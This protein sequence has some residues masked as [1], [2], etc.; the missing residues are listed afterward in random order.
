MKKLAHLVF[1]V[2][3]LPA[4]VAWADWQPSKPVEFVVTA[5]AGGGTDIFARAVQ[6]AVQKNNLMSQPIIVT[7]KGGGSGAEGYVYGKSAEGDAHKLI[8]GTHNMYVLPLA[9]KVAFTHKDLTPIAAMVFDEF[10]IWVKADSP[11]KDSKGVRRGRQGQGRPVE[12]GWRAVEGFRRARH[13]A[14]REG[15]RHE[16]DLCTVQVGRRGR[17]A[18]LGRP[19]R[20]PRQQSSRVGRQLEGG[21]GAAALRV[22]QGAAGSRAEGDRDAGLVRHPDLQVAGHRHRAIPAAPHCLSP[23]QGSRRGRRLLPGP[24]AEGCRDAGVEGVPRAHRPD[25]PRAD[26]RRISPS[27]STRTMPVSRPCS[28]SRAGWSNK[29]NRLAGSART[30]FGG[31]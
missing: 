4:S 2:A 18:A 10:L 5:G 14:A 17:C 24:D 30:R 9:A 3:L 28:R 1:A 12:D 29:G 8:F 21:Q 15:D 27:S 13:Q 6:A 26:R 16:D 23:R 31:S 25:G 20:Q 11:I 7:I 22:Q 19:S